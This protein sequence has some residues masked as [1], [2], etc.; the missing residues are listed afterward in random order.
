MAKP[1]LRF[2]EFAEEWEEKTIGNIFE[3]TNGKAHEQ[4]VDENGKYVIVNSKFISTEGKIKKY[5]N[6][7]ICPLK[8]N[9]IV[10]V[11][12]DVPN[13]R[14]M[15]KC[16]LIQE[17]D[18]Y[19]LNQ[20]ICGLRTSQNSVFYIHQISRNNY[21]LKF[22]NGVS[23]TNLRKEDVLN[24]PIFEAEDGEQKK[25]ANFLSSIDDVIQ[26]QEEEIIVF[27]EQKKGIMQKLFNR[28]VRFKADDGS[29]YPE[30]E[31]KSFDEIFYIVQNNT[32]SRDYLNYENGTVLNIHYG[33]V[34]IK[35]G[36][37]ID[38]GK[39]QIPFING[40]I[41]LDK[42]DMESYLCDGDIVIADTAEDVTVGKATEVCGAIGK[43]ILS[44][45][46]TI[47]CRPKVTF[48]SKYLG[49]FINSEK[50]H[51]LLMPLIQGIKVSS[52]SKGNIA[53]TMIIYPCRKEQQ[54][55]VDCLSAYDEAILIKKEKLEVWKEI[56]K[57][58]L[59]QM[60]A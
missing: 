27:E 1:K 53:K 3:F 29:E 39:E 54:K 33:D 25:I 45:L 41:Q 46:H 24:C 19:T 42:F 26:V 28:E 13:G 23:Q 6:D 56:K 22:D 5:T 51:N 15:S 48:V 16:F 2:P 17:D 38:V 34:L 11:M 14:A 50:Y 36:A 7:L 18:K 52:I 59:Q 12:S 57:G 47:P 20:R 37:F 40:N 32:F 9:D 49:Y 31:E 10:M 21:Y 58:L 30:W 8:K 43:K 55:I 35:Y 4:C 60:F 44:G